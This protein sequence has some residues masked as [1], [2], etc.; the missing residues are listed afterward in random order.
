MKSRKGLISVKQAYL[1]ILSVIL[2]LAIIG[3]SVVGNYGITWDEP[4]EVDMVNHNLE[5]I[6]ENKP[7]SE[8]SRHYGF[9]FNYISQLIYKTKENFFPATPNL[10]PN[11]TD[12]D[13]WLSRIWQIT[14]VKHVVTFLFS[15]ITYLSVV[16]I[17]AILAGI[18]S[19]WLGALILALFPAF[20][21]HTFFNPKDIPFAA[22]FTLGTFTGSLLLD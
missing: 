21:G 2:V 8:M 6:R 10:P 7:I 3:L 17:V 4:I 18:E 20:W 11:P 13:K 15:L 1:K 16:G 5:Y 14:R 19:A 22:M 12:K 9:Y